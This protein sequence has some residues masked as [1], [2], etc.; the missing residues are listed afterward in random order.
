MVVEAE[1][2][3]HLEEELLL[4]GQ[5][6]EPPQDQV[7]VLHQD[8][9]VGQL[10]AQVVEALQGRQLLPQ[11]E[12]H[13]LP[14]DPQQGLLPKAPLMV[15]HKDHPT[16]T[17][18]VVKLTETGQSIL[19]VKAET[20]LADQ[21]PSQQAKEVHLEAERETENLTEQELQPEPDLPIVLMEEEIQE[22]EME[23]GQGQETETDRAE[24]TDQEAETIISISGTTTI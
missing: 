12:A 21:G 6:V 24:V 18:A 1:G 4:L 11:I 17:S 9:V 8:Q 20:K 3:L 13:N 7:L 16:E 15:A 10:P 14:T 19:H 5:V 2:A 23:T 22:W